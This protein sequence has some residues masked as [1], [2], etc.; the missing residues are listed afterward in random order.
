M[1]PRTEAYVDTS[2]LIAFVDRS[3]SHHL[4]FRR[5]FSNPPE[6]I[7]TTLVIAEGHGWFLKR[8]DRVRALQFLA[9][10]E[11]LKPLRIVPVGPDEF[12]GAVKILRK[13]SDQDLSLTDAAGLYLMKAHHI[14]SCWSTDFHLGLTGV[15]LVNQYY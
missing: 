15:P 12:A 4:L 8:Y 11:D 6:L 14:Q 7:T 1:A 9:L 5:L 3:D 10:I 2:A 13:Y